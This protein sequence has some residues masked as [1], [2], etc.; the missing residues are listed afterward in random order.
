MPAEVRAADFQLMTIDFA[1]LPP[2]SAYAWMSSLIMPRPVAW[3]STL[4]PEGAT[5]VAPFSFFSGVTANPPTL[6]FVPVNDR[7]GRPKHTLRNIELVPE[8]V[9]NVVPQHLAAVMN[10]CSAPLPY[11][12]SEFGAFG[13]G[14]APSLRVRPPRVQDA[15]AAFECC[16][17]QI[18]RVGEGPMAGNIVI[19]RILAVHV[20]D[21]VLGEE[22]LPDPA[23]L[24]LI[25]R[26]GGDGY[27][28]TRDRF[29]LERP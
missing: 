7:E 19:G 8:F 28:T 4:S 16:L 26:L 20:L 17:H 13:V 18:V 1:N 3:V 23:K 24:D 21:S 11:G 10:A 9:V 5:N 25:G 29:D 12:E 22:G 6:M 2:R 27:T 15:P 14:A